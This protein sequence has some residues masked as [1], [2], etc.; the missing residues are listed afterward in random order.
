M[1]KNVVCP[2]SS[3]RVDSNISR[4]TVFINFILLVVFVI[5]LNPVPLYIV[6]ID[7]AIRAAGKNQYS[8]ICIIASN[9]IKL[10]GTKPKPIDK[11]QKVFASRL[12]LICAVLGAIF[13]ALDMA[14][15]S[16]IVVGLFVILAFS[17]AVFDLCVGCLIYN[18]IV[19]P[20]YKRKNA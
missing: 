13:L 3:E 20:F 19:F 1:F 5:S 7:Y 8:P 4:L 9:I 14:L 18:Y 10:I 15:A 12:G 11:A 2:I 6:I 16:R 17:D